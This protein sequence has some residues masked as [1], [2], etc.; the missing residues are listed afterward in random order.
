[1][2]IQA[3][4]FDVGGVLVD[5]TRIYAEWAAWLGVSSL[6]FGAMLGAVI[7]RGEH[8]LRTFEL[9]RP[10]F[11]LAAE[12]A[13][14]AAAGRPNLVLPTDFY[15]DVRPAMDALRAAGY[16]LGIA[17]NQ[18]ATIERVMAEA[19]LPA[20]VIASSE[21]WGVEK[22]DPAFFTRLAQAAGLLPSQIAYVGDRLDND[23]LPANAAGMVSV[24]I[25]RGPWGAI[26]AHWTHAAQA[27]LQVSTLTELPAVLAAL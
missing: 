15:P 14:R 18:P 19:A 2:T 22:P 12:E 8:H 7:Q 1:M 9:L 11:D 3:V 20:G 10:G 4:F 16:R 27:R 24:F 5:E 26:H 25:P 21:S 23:V 6:T 13:A 17:G